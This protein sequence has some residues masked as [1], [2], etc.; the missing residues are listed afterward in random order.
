MYFS[1]D[2]EFH[3]TTLFKGTQKDLRGHFHLSI[4]PD[5]LSIKIISLRSSNRPAIFYNFDIF[6]MF[7]AFFRIPFGKRA[8]S[9]NGPLFSLLKS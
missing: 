6:W 2:S 9:K 7:F 4:S 1:A 8:A 3:A 5:P